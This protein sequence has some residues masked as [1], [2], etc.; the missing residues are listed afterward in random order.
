MGRL[1]EEMTRL[2]EE[3]VDLDSQRKDFINELKNEANNMRSRIQS[4]LAETNR[5]VREDLRKVK[6]DLKASVSEMRKNLNN[7]RNQMKKQLRADLKNFVSGLRSE[8]TEMQSGFNRELSELTLETRDNLE[9]VRSEF[10]KYVGVLRN[11]VAALRKEYQEDIAGAR[12][13]WRGAPARRPVAETRTAWPPDKQ[14]PEREFT[15]DDLTAIAGIGPG[16]MKLLNQAGVYTFAQLSQALPETLKDVFEKTVGIADLE[17][18]IKK[19]GEL[20]E[21][22]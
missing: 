7:E 3:I 9:D 17:R 5:F 20:A 19:A 12:Q 16:R 1:T 11:E 21:K 8:V 2:R 22:L 6:P 15:P 13:G 10:V 14:M 18:W 4:E